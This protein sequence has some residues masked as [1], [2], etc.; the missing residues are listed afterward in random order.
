MSPLCMSTAGGRDLSSFLLNSHSE[1]GYQELKITNFS[2]LH[3]LYSLPRN[4]INLSASQSDTSLYS[5]VSKCMKFFGGDEYHVQSSSE[6]L[7]ISLFQD[8]QLFPPKY[9]RV[10]GIPQEKVFQKP[11]PSCLG[12]PGYRQPV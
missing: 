3:N 4:K 7:H 1:V 6:F 8:F 12:S 2:I 5:H 9:L 11:P 10:K